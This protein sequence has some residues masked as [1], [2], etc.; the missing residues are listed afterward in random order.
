MNK[1]KIKQI[2][3]DICVLQHKSNLHTRELCVLVYNS[4]A[5]W[6][7][8][9]L[10]LWSATEGLFYGPFKD[11]LQ[12]PLSLYYISVCVHSAAFFSSCRFLSHVAKYPFLPPFPTY[13]FCW[14]VFVRVIFWQCFF[15]SGIKCPKFK[16]GPSCETEWVGVCNG[17]FQ[18]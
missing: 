12:I 15:F 16:N 11:Y 2:K 18:E 17:F 14:N 8:F 1:M 9:L 13:S 4:P 3:S 6:W 5:C 10:F 7:M